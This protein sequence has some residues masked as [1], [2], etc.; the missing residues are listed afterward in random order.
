MYG[1]PLSFNQGDEESRVE[2]VWMATLQSLR[3][4]V[5]S[6][7]IESVDEAASLVEAGGE[8]LRFPLAS[9]KTKTHLA[10]LA[11]TMP[12]WPGMA[13]LLLTVT[14][15]SSLVHGTCVLFESKLSDECGFVGGKVKIIDGNVI[16]R[17]AASSQGRYYAKLN[18]VSS[19]VVSIESLL[20]GKASVI[21]NPHEADEA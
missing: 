19:F 8:D 12:T 18:N 17:P 15:R 7:Q 21:R 13:R 3:E 20:Q 1:L 2:R 16:A 14:D 4:I 10:E 5:P 11:Y 6:E 9:A